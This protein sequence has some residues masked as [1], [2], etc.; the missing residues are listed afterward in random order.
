M[1]NTKPVVWRVGPLAW[2]VFA[3]GAVISIFLFKEG[4]QHMVTAWETKAEYSHAYL[5]PFIA[6]FLIWQKKDKLEQ[7][8]FEGSWVA[9]SIRSRRDAGRCA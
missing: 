2:G 3:I 1:N 8:Q 9:L 4:L 7:I 6:L 5:L